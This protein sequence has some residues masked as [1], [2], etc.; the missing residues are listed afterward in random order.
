MHNMTFYRPPIPRTAKGG[1]I[2]G[3]AWA[4]PPVGA[5]SQRYTSP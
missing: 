3:S 2:G 1:M 5:K 4:T